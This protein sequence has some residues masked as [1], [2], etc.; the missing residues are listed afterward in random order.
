MAANTNAGVIERRAYY[1][2]WRASNRDRVR[3]YNHSYWERRAQKQQIIGGDV[4]KQ[5]GANRT[6]T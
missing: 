2:A 4:N 6:T 5:A 3:K 1:R